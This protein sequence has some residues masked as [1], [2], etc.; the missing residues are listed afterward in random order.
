MSA[1]TRTSRWSEGTW[2]LAWTIVFITQFVLSRT[3]WD[4]SLPLRMILAA[5]QGTTITI[6]MVSLTRVSRGLP[7]LRWDRGLVFRILSN[8]LALALSINHVQALR[9]LSLHLPS[10]IYVLGHWLTALLLSVGLPLAVLFVI[11]AWIM[12]RRRATWQAWDVAAAAY[13]G[14]VMSLMC[15]LGSTV[16]PFGRANPAVGN[17]WQLLTCIVLPIILVILVVGLW[18]KFKLHGTPRTDTKSS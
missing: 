7:L 10:A 11:C 1:Q 17:A 8:L 2:L 18:V 13:G 5:L 9:S 16:H 4:T 6:P 3:G 15:M 12:S 14:A